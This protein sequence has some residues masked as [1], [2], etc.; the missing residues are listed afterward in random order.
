MCTWKYIVLSLIFTICAHRDSLICET[1]RCLVEQSEHNVHHVALSFV[2]FPVDVA[3]VLIARYY[4]FESYYESFSVLETSIN[5]HQFMPI[6][7]AG[8]SI[9]KD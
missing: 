6:S 3:M 4:L 5:S 2:Q 1:V 9:L 7:D 8:I